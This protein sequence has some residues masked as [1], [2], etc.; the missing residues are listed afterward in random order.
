[1]I[2]TTS[3]IL[4]TMTDGFIALDSE[5]TVTYFNRQAEH[6]LHYDRDEI[7]ECTLTDV[8]P[9]EVSTVLAECIAATIS[10][11]QTQ[12]VTL[13][14]PGL[15]RW[16]KFQLYP[17]APGVLMYFS[18]VTDDVRSQAIREQVQSALRQQVNEHTRRLEQ[19]NEKL[20]YDSMHDALTGLPNRSFFMDCLQ[21]AINRTFLQEPFTVLFL[22]FDRFK[23]INDSLGHVLGDELLIALAQRLRQ[24]IPPEGIMARLGGDEFIFLLN[25]NSSAVTAELLADKISKALLQPFFIRGRE[26]YMTASIGILIASEGYE[27][28]GDVLR[29]VDLAMYQAKANGKARYAF[30]DENMREQIITQVTLESD[31]RLAIER[32]HI[33]VFYQPIIDLYEDKLAGF[34]A[35][36]RWQHPERGFVS[37]TKFI[38]IAE[39]SDIILDIDNWVFQQAC[40]QLQAWRQQNPASASLSVSLNVSSKQF[41]RAGF[42]AQV[43]HILKTHELS[44]SSV[45]IEMTERVVMDDTF[46]VQ[47]NLTFLNDLGVHLHI[48]DFGTGYSSLSY[49][50]KFPAH[51]IKIDRSFVDVMMER[52]ETLELVRTLI[53]MAHTLGLQVVAEGVESREQLNV[54]K[55]LG[56]RYVQGYFFSKPMTS[57]EAYHYI[58]RYQKPRLAQENLITVDN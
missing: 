37:P 51:S 2:P 45:N 36:A 30:F 39:E 31:L 35:L 56:C 43:E 15:Q 46:G 48:D 33:Q 22:D 41:S 55:E 19:L 25:A 21:K 12:T 4:E 13:E 28:A 9:E 11:Q 53:T 54:L 50:H 24:F 14:Y 16:L 18:D 1:M 42:G 20:L 5:G 44:P 29:D 47:K 58:Q 7:L 10:T 57:D 17:K 34:E 27:R 49:L 52:H 40:Q 32:K 6:I 3:D 8:L 38:P 26:I 23:R